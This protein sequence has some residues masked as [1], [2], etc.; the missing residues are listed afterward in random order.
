VVLFGVWIGC[1]ALIPYS[2]L[3][4]VGKAKVAAYLQIGEVVPYLIAAWFLTKYYGAIGAAVVW[5]VRYTVDSAI[6]FWLVRRTDSHIPTL[7]FT[8]RRLRSIAA[9]VLLAAVV[10]GS[11]HITSGLFPRIGIGAVIATTYAACIWS[12]VLT[13]GERRGLTGL[14]AEVRRRPP[15]I[16]SG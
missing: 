5:T 12:G 9:P 4:A 7:P 13:E 15:P 8:E 11:V 3:L 14:I 16:T 2:Y 6:I 1:L 10:Y